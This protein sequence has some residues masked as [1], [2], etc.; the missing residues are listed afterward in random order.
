MSIALFYMQLTSFK[1][2]EFRSVIEVSLCR[3]IKYPACKVKLNKY[4][5]SF[6]MLVFASDMLA[7]ADSL[8][9]ATVNNGVFQVLAS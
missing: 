8:A 1:V 3:S 2:L 7:K 6:H 4:L 9:G 5:L